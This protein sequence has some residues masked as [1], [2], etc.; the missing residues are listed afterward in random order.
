MDQPE[1][2]AMIDAAARA[3]SI[4]HFVR[5]EM[6]RLH[7]P[8]LA[9]TVLREGQVLLTSAFGLANLELSVPVSTESVFEIA[10]ITK[11]FTA[12]G[13]MMLVQEGKIHL[14]EKIVR[15]L[16]DIPMTW[17][18]VTVRHLLTHTSGIKSYTWL[19]DFQ[20]AWQKDE[21]IPR[22][23]GFPLEFPPG[24]EYAYNNT[25]F[26]LVGLIIEAVSGKSIGEFKEERIFAPLQ[27]A[28]TR[29]NDYSIIV[30]NRVSGY[31]WEEGELRHAR[32]GAPAWAN[33]AGWT[34]STILDLVKW[35]AALYTERLL[36]QSSLEQMWNPAVLNSG[37]VVE[38]G[39]GWSINSIA[40]KRVVGH[41]GGT[42]GFATYIARFINDRL[43][44]I[45]LMN[46]G[47]GDSDPAYQ[48][49]TGVARLVDPPR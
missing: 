31:T 19:P 12:A 43:T 46:G 28:A 16:P 6:Q 20:Y 40:G 36:Q 8:G 4:D 47:S 14:D 5:A 2:R 7:C 17:S 3:E 18:E 30:K 24:Q 34:L 35:D 13:T 49:A 42:R 27:M 29:P 21:I 11:S 15:Y 32:G 33:G 10:S 41:G 22:V 23:A 1:E 38:Y 25:G 9:V 45:V 48:V 39:L 37:A 26:F 44:V